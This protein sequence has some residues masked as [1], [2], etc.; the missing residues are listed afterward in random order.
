MD[1]GWGWNAA[2]SR[3]SV[4]SREREP[5]LYAEDRDALASR[6]AML[7]A[8]S[9]SSFPIY[10]VLSEESA[11]VREVGGIRAADS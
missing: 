6:V 7:T 11:R 3:G 8:A 10:L 5:P 9:R 2:P 1:V 4:G